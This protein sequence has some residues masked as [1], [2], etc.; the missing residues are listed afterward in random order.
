MY[1]TTELTVFFT[2]LESFVVTEALAIIL[3]LLHKRINSKNEESAE[4]S[5]FFPM[6][7]FGRRKEKD[8]SPAAWRKFEEET[9]CMRVL[10]GYVLAMAGYCALAFTFTDGEKYRMAGHILTQ[11]IPG[12]GVALCV[13]NFL[14]L[15]NEA[16]D[17]YARIALS[18][19][20]S[21]LCQLTTKEKAKEMLS[22]ISCILDHLPDHGKQ[23][24]GLA[25]KLGKARCSEKGPLFIE[26]FFKQIRRYN[27][28]IDEENQLVII[29]DMSLTEDGVTAIS[30]LAD[31]THSEFFIARSN[32]SVQ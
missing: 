7:L 24:K 20:Y 30:E 10:S 15:N 31:L 29:G 6:N 5:A 1:V 28:H 26:M 17:K 13:T 2:I 18:A 9:F 27:P 3:L 21:Y 14:F 25:I 8:E 22:F 16:K 19:G 12:V 4:K 23:F 32:S 11:I